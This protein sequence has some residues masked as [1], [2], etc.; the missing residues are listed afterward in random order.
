MITDIAVFVTAAGVFAAVFGLRQSNRERLRQF[1]ALYVLRYWSILD[2]LSLE[3]LEGSAKPA[4]DGDLKAIRAYLLLCEDE[5]EMRSRGYIAD[6][7]YRIW[8]ESAVAQLGQP[9][10]RAVWKQVTDEAAF[11][12]LHLKQLCARPESYDPLTAGFTRRWLRGL[13]GIGTF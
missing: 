4:S 12:Y 2:Q 7:T 1:E 6:T 10:F 3:A 5:L 11:P 13:C 9:I 8:A